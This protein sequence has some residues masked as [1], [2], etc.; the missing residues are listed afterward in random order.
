MDQ[1]NNST[2]VPI[3]LPPLHSCPIVGHDVGKRQCTEFTQVPRRNSEICAPLKCKS[4]WRVCRICVIQGYLKVDSEGINSETGLCSF[5]AAD[6]TAH[7]KYSP[8]RE[9]DE[10]FKKLKGGKKPKGKTLREYIKELQKKIPQQQG[11][12]R[13]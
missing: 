12:R 10:Q 9:A 2:A 3:Q 4:K 13:E 7:R 5:H 1:S 6:N 8:V 11:R